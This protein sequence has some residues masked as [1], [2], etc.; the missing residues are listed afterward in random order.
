MPDFRFR[1]AVEKLFQRLQRCRVANQSQFI[2]GFQ[3][4]F[5]ALVFE[6]LDVILN[7][8]VRHFELF[9]QGGEPR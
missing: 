9:P 8:T 1:I 5:G 6:P 7:N 2:D 4:H 3:T